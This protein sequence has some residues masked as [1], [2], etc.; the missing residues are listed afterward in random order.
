MD[1]MG[2]K[3]AELGHKKR[4]HYENSKI[5]YG[6]YVQFPFLPPPDRSYTSFPLSAYS[7]KKKTPRKTKR[8]KTL[9]AYYSPYISMTAEVVMRL[10][11]T[12]VC[13]PSSLT[14]KT[15]LRVSQLIPGH[16]DI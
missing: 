5:G 12:H 4:L 3:T 13:S 9:G 15:S 16:D 6:C 7:A 1:A 2:M 10:R 14:P 11:I 8:T